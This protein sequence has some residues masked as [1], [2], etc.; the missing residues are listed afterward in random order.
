MLVAGSILSTIIIGFFVPKKFLG[1]YFILCALLLSSLYFFFIPSKD[2]D[3]YRHYQTMYFMKFISW[4]DLLEFKAIDIGDYLLKE[5]S[6]N[7]PGYC[8]YAYAI[9]KIGV[10]ELL[11]VITGIIVYGLPI[12]ILTKIGYKKN[13]EKWKL[14]LGYIFI[15]FNID[16]LSISGIRNIL[17]TTIFSYVLYLDLIKKKNR[18]LCFGAYAVICTIHSMGVMLLAFRLI[19]FFY[20][21]RSNNRFIN[22]ILIVV[23]FS[24]QRITEILISNI[25]S[26]SIIG[27]IIYRA[28]DSFILYSENGTENSIFIQGTAAALYFLCFIICKFFKKYSSNFNDYKE[29]YQYIMIIFSYILSAVPMRDIFM[30]FRLILFVLMIPIIVEISSEFF[31]KRIFSIKRINKNNISQYSILIEIIIFIE[32]FFSF[33]INIYLRYLAIDMNFLI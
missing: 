5:Y 7:Y 6:R 24:M 33:L 19:L 13:I 26:N 15:V 9:G 11:P 10:K 3:L 27:G 22:L 30:R 4:K 31:G 28:L 1:K 23:F 8:L 16:F 2:F 20:S 25:N 21:R 29:W 17:A 14:L 18:I 32:I 12:L